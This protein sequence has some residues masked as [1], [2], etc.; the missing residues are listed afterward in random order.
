M[1]TQIEKSASDTSARTSGS[2]P[3]DGVGYSANLQ[4]AIEYHCR[5]QII[6]EALSKLCPH[7]AKMLNVNLS[8]ESEVS[9]EA[10]ESDNG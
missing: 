4:Q 3:F 8:N 1:N 9:R 10:K 2:T 5:G 6:P 7:H